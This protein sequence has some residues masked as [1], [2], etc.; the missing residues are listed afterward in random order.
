M[1][2]SAFKLALTIEASERD[3]KKDL[4]TIPRRTST[5]CSPLVLKVPFPATAAEAIN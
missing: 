4:L 5:T 1:Y 3:S 2:D